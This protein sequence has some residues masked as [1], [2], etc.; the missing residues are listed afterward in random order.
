[1]HKSLLF[2]LLFTT[3]CIAQAQG[4]Y[5]TGATGLASSSPK[6][7]AWL[8]IASLA[9]TRAQI[10]DIAEVDYTAIRSTS[11]LNATGPIQLQSSIRLAIAT[12]FRMFSPRFSI[13]ALAD[14][15]IATSAASGGT[16]TGSAYGAGAIA[17]IRL[18]ND[19]V[20]VAGMQSLR[21]TVGGVTQIWRI[22][23]GFLTH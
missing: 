17:T 2:A 3:S 13:Y 16:I 8:A 23:F 21:T 20:L 10:Y 12:P 9:S 22:G 5:G 11:R 4:F 15:G 6:P 1:M 7:S 14:A 19:L 18:R